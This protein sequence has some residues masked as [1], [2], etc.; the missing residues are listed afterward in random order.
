M[1]DPA[2]L[3]ARDLDARVQ[4]LM[5]T[6]GERL[7]RLDREVLRELMRRAG[8]REGVVEALLDRNIQWDVQL[9]RN[10]LLEAVAE[11]ALALRQGDKAAGRGSGR[12]GRTSRGW[13]V[14]GR[15][16]ACS[17]GRWPRPPRAARPW[18]SRGRCCGCEGKGRP[19][20][21]GV[22]AWGLVLATV[23]MYLAGSLAR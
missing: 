20:R 16:R 2:S 23:A 11:A 18:R 8:E 9:E 13:A 15:R 19:R 6:L 21:R 22:L 1:L 12:A 3:S 10:R 17:G 7:T 4:R 5:T 14:S